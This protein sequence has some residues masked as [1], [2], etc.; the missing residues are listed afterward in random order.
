M[1]TITMYEKIIY[2]WLNQWW[3][4]YCLIWVFDSKLIHTDNFR[5][6]SEDVTNTHYP[7]HPHLEDTSQVE[8]NILCI[9]LKN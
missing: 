4:E 6:D 3:E 5:R 9:F 1:T 2:N 7:L 8:K